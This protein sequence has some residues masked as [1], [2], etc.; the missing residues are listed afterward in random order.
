M[1]DMHR[2]DEMIVVADAGAGRAGW[3]HGVM[4]LPPRHQ[5]M[6]PEGAHPAPGH[7]SGMA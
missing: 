5:W 2:H 1:D 4:L 6:Q 7:A 3:L